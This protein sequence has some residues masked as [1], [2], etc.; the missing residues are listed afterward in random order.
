MTEALLHLARKKG[1]AFVLIQLGHADLAALAAELTARCKRAES[2]VEWLTWEREMRSR[3]PVHVDPD[4]IE[5]YRLWVERLTKR[6]E[7]LKAKP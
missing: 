4:R 1:L 3:K 6:V 2:E 5:L 7:R